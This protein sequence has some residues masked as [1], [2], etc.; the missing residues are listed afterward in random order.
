MARATARYPGDRSVLVLGTA[1]TVIYV[2]ICLVAM[3]YTLYNTWAPMLIAPVLILVS[4]PAFARQAVRE[5][6]RRVFWFL[7]LVLL[8]KII[9]GTL[10][11]YHVTVNIN[12]GTDS[13]KY[14]RAG[15]EIAERFRDGDFDTE[16]PN[17]SGTHFV[18]FATG[19]VYTVIGP[20]RL[21]GFMVFSW[22][23]FW[24]LFYF[25]RA[26]VVAMPEGRVRSYGRFVFLLPS[27]LYWPSSLGKE[28]WMVFGLG[29]AAFGAARV[30]SGSTWRGL[31]IAGL[32]LWLA[33][34]VRPHTAG[35]LAI[36]LAFGY[37]FRRPREELRQLAPIVKVV[38]LAA[39]VLVALLLVNKTD[40]FLKDDGVDTSGGIL[41]TQEEIVR[42]SSQGGSEFVP[43]VLD[44]PARAP[45]ATFTVLFRPTLLE[46]H[47]LHSLISGAE[48][49]FLI[50]FCLFR[51]RWITAGF[52]SVRRQ[53][54]VAFAVAYTGMF[55]IAFSSIANFGQLARQ[56]T[57]VLPLLVVLLCSLMTPKSEDSPESSA[58]L[59]TASR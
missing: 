30:L 50:L 46:A 27:I 58:V 9:V 4:L 31:A 18:R 56:R 41:S 49:A 43:S 47:N 10:I 19:V 52:K 54:Y 23:A 11:R 13:N 25:Y 20:T 53:P 37:L 8:L 28:S 33:T 21:G 42:R 34:L 38:S 16:L 14:H 35:I 59:E 44:S 40:E 1:A 48:G 36:A 5:K 45:L 32:G 26:F 17:L 29:I 55:V 24:G 7:L 22:L 3:E 15:V 2:A 39:V 51:F 6:S 12:G 57:Q